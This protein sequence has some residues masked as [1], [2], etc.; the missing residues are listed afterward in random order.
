MVVSMP[1]AF[2]ERMN[3]QLGEKETAQLLNEWTKPA[4]MALRIISSKVTVEHL[5]THL[6]IELNQVPWCP[7]GFYMDAENRFGKLPEHAAGLFYIQEPSA[8]APVEA[9]DVHPGMKV[10]DL[11]AAPGGK[12]TQI[13]SKMFGKGILVCNDPHSDRVKALAKNVERCALGSVVVLNDQP[14]RIAN[15][16]SGY[17]DRILV[18]APCS[19]EG[20]FRK[21]EAIQR[22]WTLDQ[23][24]KDAIVQKEVLRAALTML[25]PGGRL[26]YSTC[27]FSVE[28]NEAVLLD[29]LRSD[30]QVR[31]V[32][33]FE[34]NHGFAPGRPDW[35]DE[36]LST[37]E[38]EQLKLAK[39]IWP[40]LVRGEGHFFAVFEKLGERPTE[41]AIPQIS[42]LI[43]ETSNAW[44]TWC[45]QQL[46]AEVAK[47]WIHL[48]SRMSQVNDFLFLRPEEQLPALKGVRIF[49]EGLLLGELAGVKGPKR[50]MPSVGI[51]LQLRPIDVQRS[52]MFANDDERVIRYLRGE[53]I[54]VH[55]DEVTVTEGSNE[56]GMVL[57]CVCG[58]ALGWARSQGD[59]MLKNDYPAGW[60]WN[61]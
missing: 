7:D 26:V 48:G 58:F 39:R 47:R 22:H 11:C 44:I 55:D 15:I 23:P 57:V 28:E 46:N 53:S 31:I 35:L 30:Q 40:H 61:G 6:G 18:D 42:T 32:P 12:T 8:M 25:A 52:I 49:R 1:N 24:A 16:F 9:L 27:T 2:V 13:A 20:M 4:A 34:D 37:D 60:R 59:G 14:K 21:D 33:V 41:R 50:F 3:I 17:F 19:G 45:E 10:L 36:V 29:A 54:V 51:A 38:V 5:F 43:K 56:K